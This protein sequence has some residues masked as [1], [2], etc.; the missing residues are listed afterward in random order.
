[1]TFYTIYQT[2]NLLDGKIYVGKHKTE[3]L[4]D[5]YFGSGKYLWKAIEKDGLENF[6]KCILFIFENEEQMNAKEAELVDWDFISRDD[7]YNR[8]PGGK[9]GWNFVNNAESASDR[10]RRGGQNAAKTGKIKQYWK[11]GRFDS[12]LPILAQNFKGRHHSS[13]TKQKISS[14]NSKMIG[15]KNSQ[16]GSMWI[17]DGVLNRKIKRDLDT[18][19]DGWYRGRTMS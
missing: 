3:N 14:A 16:F 18:I 6:S 15:P 7:T 11:E 5:S 13:E 4:N 2:T 10:R 12:L 17:T 19:P 9:G 8:T 1:M